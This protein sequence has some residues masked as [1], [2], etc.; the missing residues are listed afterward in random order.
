MSLLISDVNVVSL[1]SIAGFDLAMHAG[2]SALVDIV[3]QD[4]FF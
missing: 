4:L 3:V 2:N 1:S